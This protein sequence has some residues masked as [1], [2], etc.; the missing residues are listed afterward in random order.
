VFTENI[1]VGILTKIVSSEINI[2]SSTNIA[3]TSCYKLSYLHNLLRMIYPYF[4]KKLMHKNNEKCKMY[5][6]HSLLLIDKVISQ[7]HKI[8]KMY[9]LFLLLTLRYSK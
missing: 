8:Y 5:I 3:L 2:N 6:M 7:F 1:N 4:Y 9:L